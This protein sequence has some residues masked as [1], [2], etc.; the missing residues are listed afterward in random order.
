MTG[1]YMKMPMILTVIACAL[2]HWTKWEKN[3]RPGKI[4]LQYW[5]GKKTTPD[6]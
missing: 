4:P 5:S 6:I 1:K 3:Q 2:S